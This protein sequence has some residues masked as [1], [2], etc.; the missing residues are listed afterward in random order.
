[1]V[2][3]TITF[4][5]P[6]T[7][8]LI[9]LALYYAFVMMVAAILTNINE[10]C[11]ELAKEKRTPVSGFLEVK[12]KS[13][14]L[15]QMELAY[16]KAFEIK[17][18]INEVFQGPIL[19]STIQ[20]FHS[21]AIIIG[22]TLHMIPTEKQDLRWLLEVGTVFSH[23]VLYLLEARF[24]LFSTP[25]AARERVYT[26]QNA[27]CDRSNCRP[28]DVPLACGARIARLLPVD[29]EKADYASCAYAFWL[30]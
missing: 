12:S 25:L 5:L 6:Q 17:T 23:D 16:V 13:I 26:L 28:L 2:L 22:R 15:R 24:F 9:T 21:A 27:M 7:L 18:Y 14:T 10:H 3:V 4:N 8:Q 19:A 30:A 11:L 29:L 1:M 20:C